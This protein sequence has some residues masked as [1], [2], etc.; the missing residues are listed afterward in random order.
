M[1]EN[2]EN[3][4]VQ[5]QQSQQQ[6]G[7]QTKTNAEK[8][9][10]K[11]PSGNVPDDDDKS[12]IDTLYDKINS[13]IGGNNPHQYL[14][15]TIPGQ[16]LSAEDFAYNYK[17]NEAKGPTV[18]ANESRLANK[19]F[20]PCRVAG[21][22]NGLTLPYQY[23]SALD[24]LTPKV[25]AKIAKAKNELRKLLLSDYP[26]TFEDDKPDKKHTL[27]E[28]FFRLYDDFVLANR[29]WAEKQNEKRIQ[30]Q[31]KYKHNLD[32]NARMNDEYLTWYE[33][34]AESELRII[35]EKRS[36]VLSV[37]SPNDMKIL[38]G[39]LDSGSGAELEQAR[40]TLTNTQK[41]TPTGG[42]V[43]PVK[44]NP[45]NWF[46]LL[47]TSFV[48]S[49][50]LKSPGALAMDLKALSSRRLR[51]LAQINEVAKLLPA[52]DEL[53]NLRNTVE[54]ANNTFNSAR[55]KLIASYGE[56]MGGVFDAALDLLPLFVGEDSNGQNDGI[57][58]KLVRGREDGNNAGSKDK[59][60]IGEIVENLKGSL[61]KVS[62][63]QQE[64]TEN[65]QNLADVSAALAKKQNLT[66]LSSILEPLKT[67]LA[68]VEDEIKNL[69]AQIQISNATNNIG[70]QSVN[71]PKVPAGFTQIIINKRASTLQ[72]SSS[73]STSSG[74]TTHGVSFLFGGYDVKNSSSSS[75]FYSVAN[76]TDS[77]IKI[78]MNIAKVGIEREW[79]NPGV[80]ALT[81]D[82]YNVTTSKISPNPSIEY[83][84]MSDERLNDMARPEM[85]FPCYP[86][87]MVIARDI[88]IE[89]SSSASSMEEFAD[90]V[91]EHASTGGGFLIFGGSRS[92]NKSSS[93]SG[94]N[95]SSNDKCIT[96]RF[97]TPQII[98]YYLQATPADKSVPLDN[99]SKA[100]I[101][102]GF[103]TISRFVS[104]YRNIIKEMEEVNHN[105]YKKQDEN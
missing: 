11:A 19:L 30:L 59:S 54:N 20:T 68:E 57:L 47:D 8:T 24:L 49:D 104:E 17:K 26:Y 62:K 4:N 100:E 55:N 66:Q 13:I 23:R 101:D 15:L 50:L 52:D 96:I 76:A 22:D 61:I 42:Y 92:S 69:Q 89:I 16:A 93:S 44:F 39:I 97:D 82:M 80:F 29:Q 46:E 56:G 36:K 75:S 25:N 7:K 40:Q 86:V 32:G 51:I 21:A 67:Q 48:P 58:N 85:V 105:R 38:E 102:A 53:T 71:P 88:S 60:N 64:L 83:T 35:D 3:Q 31:E 1:P 34:V 45:T 18:E 78:G 79:F 43:F 74:V 12:F 84:Q 87:A 81:K 73:Q 91:E 2:E 65:A 94:V 41:L 6:Q 5:E 9:D 70:G 72:K 63:Q 10:K 28:V 95:A 103:V 99:I 14:M 27:Q 37:F 33:S 98:G 77:T 90:S